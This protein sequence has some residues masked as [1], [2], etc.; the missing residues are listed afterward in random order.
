MDINE[1]V[2]KTI[3][4]STIIQSSTN[5]SSQI[6]QTKSTMD[7]IGE[8]MKNVLLSPITLGQQMPADQIGN[9]IQ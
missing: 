9:L 5:S 6:Q 1:N 8:S 2:G 3:T 7:R 4:T